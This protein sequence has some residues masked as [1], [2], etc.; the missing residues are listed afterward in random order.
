M[1]KQPDPEKLEIGRRIKLARD[2]K[3]LSRSEL[4]GLLG[5]TESAVGQWESGWTMP[6]MRVFDQLPKVLSVAREWLLTGSDQIQLTRPKDILEEEVV[7]LMHK[8]S[9]RQKIK[10]VQDLTNLVG[11]PEDEPEVPGRK[12]NS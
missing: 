4:A 6:S 10:L 1:K 5:V 11:E 7:R 9:F 3:R 12:S 8:M 2:K